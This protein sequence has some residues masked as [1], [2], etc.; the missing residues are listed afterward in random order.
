MKHLIVS[1]LALLVIG[2]VA[3]IMAQRVDAPTYGQ[4]GAFAVG[5]REL[6]IDDPTRPLTATLW[7]PALNPDDAEAVTIYRLGLI[8]VTGSA[9]RDAEV[10]PSGGPYPLV[11]FSHGNG[12][13]R[14][15][16][17]FFTER[18]ASY[19]FIVMAVDHPDDTALDALAGT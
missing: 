2:G 10:D 1:F 5:T 8:A 7:Y 18:L 17:L 6:T 19:G 15:Q 14:F 11:I 12:G 4:S 3:P 16:S 9:L 13:M